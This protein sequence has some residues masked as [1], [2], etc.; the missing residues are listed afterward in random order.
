M[1]VHGAAGCAERAVAAD[2]RDATGHTGVHCRERLPSRQRSGRDFFQ[3]RP[4][5]D[6]SLLIVIGDVSGKGLKA[7]MTVS[8]IVGALRGCALRTP[9]EVLAYL[10]SAL[11]GQVSGFFTCCAA[12]IEAEGKVRIANAGA[13]FR[14][15]STARS[16]LCFMVC[17]WELPMKTLTQRKSGSWVQAIALP[18]SRTE[19]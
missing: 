3:V 5:D 4:G 15:I 1:D 19:L 6:G 14:R 13:I 11:H 8:A 2:S 16:W 10:N 18:F 7:A 12:L 17:R 9:V